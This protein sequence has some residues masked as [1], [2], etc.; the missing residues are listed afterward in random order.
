MI[1][2]KLFIICSSYHFIFLLAF[3][4]TRGELIIYSRQKFI[5][6]WETFEDNMSDIALQEQTFYDSKP[7]TCVIDM[8]NSIRTYI[9]IEAEVDED[10]VETIKGMDDT[11]TTTSPKAFTV[12]VK[13]KKKKSVKFLNYVHVQVDKNP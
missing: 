6:E 13:T 11:T 9:K 8:A 7:N 1:P 5:M 10:D 2:R 3:K 4:R 12:G